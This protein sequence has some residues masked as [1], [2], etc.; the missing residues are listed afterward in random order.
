MPPRQQTAFKIFFFRYL[1]Y[2]IFFFSL[3]LLCKYFTF[4]CSS[5]FFFLLVVALCVLPSSHR[6]WR[7]KINHYV[8]NLHFFFFKPPTS[9]LPLTSPRCQIRTLWKLGEGLLL[10][11][12]LRRKGSVGGRQRVTEFCMEK[13]KL[14]ETKKLHRGNDI[15]AIWNVFVKKKKKNGE[16]RPRFGETLRS[17]GTSFFLF[18]CFFQRWFSVDSGRFEIFGGFSSLDKDRKENR[19]AIENIHT[20]KTWS[21]IKTTTNNASTSLCTH[22]KDW[23][24]DY[25]FLICLFVP[26]FVCFLLLLYLPAKRISRDSGL[27]SGRESKNKNDHRVGPVP[28]L[29]CDESRAIVKDDCVNQKKKYYVLLN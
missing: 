14:R 15:S 12:R 8:R 4:L 7:K 9:S 2:G 24:H 5:T 20:T 21:L 22:S 16:K 11:N 29:H 28:K 26:P 13:P 18:F 25:F 19:K 27:G 1:Y 6:S 23:R 17:W 10:D 3:L